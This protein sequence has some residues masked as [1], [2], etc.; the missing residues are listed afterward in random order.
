MDFGE[1]KTPVEKTKEG[2]S[3]GTYLR[4][5]DASLIVNCIESHGKNLMIILFHLKLD[6]FCYIGL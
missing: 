5:I 3:G 2:A 1:N 6:R 4:G